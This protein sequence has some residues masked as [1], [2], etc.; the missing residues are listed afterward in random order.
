MSPAPRLTL[1]ALFRQMRAGLGDAGR[2][3][4]TVEFQQRTI[5]GAGE[6]P[7][8]PARL[9]L[10]TLL[11]YEDRVLDRAQVALRGSGGRSRRF[12]VA[13]HGDAYAYSLDG[14]ERW[15]RVAAHPRMFSLEEFERELGEIPVEDATYDVLNAVQ[16]AGA[17]PPSP[18]SVQSEPS[19]GGIRATLPERFVDALDVSLDRGAFLRLLHIFAADIDDERDAPLLN[20]FSVSMEAADDVALH[21]WWSLS[22]TALAAADA[23]VKVRCGVS[24]R[25]AALGGAQP[26]AV[27]LDAALPD[28]ADLDGVWGFLHHG[29]P[30]AATEVVEPEAG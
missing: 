16:G 20:A 30:D 15:G 1:G 10:E 12:M 27:R 3:R 14:G 18:P 2:V 19:G 5:V 21:Y 29:A 8:E 17:P 24:I 25:V 28:V 22:D 11:E 7:A 13:R 26:A 9:V 6:G 23:P 4:V